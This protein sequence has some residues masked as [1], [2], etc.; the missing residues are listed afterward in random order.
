MLQAALGQAPELSAEA[1]PAGL[2]RAGSIDFSFPQGPNDFTGERV[3]TGG[4]F[5]R[6][7]QFMPDCG[8]WR[9]IQPDFHRGYG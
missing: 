3:T 2:Q 8:C 1:L 9:V 7:A 6:P 4:Q 5:W